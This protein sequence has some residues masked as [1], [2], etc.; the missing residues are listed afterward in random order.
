[1]AAN[2]VPA[3]FKSNILP[4]YSQAC[5]IYPTLIMQTLAK[6]SLILTQESNVQFGPPSLLV[7]YKSNLSLSFFPSYLTA[8][9]K[10]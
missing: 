6:N 4:S 8:I 10:R 3:I 7:A 1:M 5:N 2:I 9:C